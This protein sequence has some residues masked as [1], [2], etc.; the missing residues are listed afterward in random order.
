M[1]EWKEVRLGDIYDVHNGLSKGGKFFGSGFPFLTFSVVFNNYFVPEELSSLVQS[2]EKERL[3]CSIK[4]GD[5]FITR[6]S[7]TAEELGMSCVAL[8]DYPNATYNGFTKRL[9]KKD[10]CQYEVDSRYIGYY[11]RSRKFRSLFMGLSGSMSTRA[12]L[13]NGDLLNMPVSLPSLSNQR[14]IASILSSLDKKIETYNKI[15]ANLEEMAQAIFKNWF[16]DF[17]PFKDG[18]FVES[19]LGMIP[20]G[21]RVGTIG[22]ITT[23][24]N[25]SLK[26]KQKL[27]TIEY[28]DTGS[29]TDNIISEIQILNADNDKIPSRA[30][31]LVANGDIVYSSVRPNQRHFGILINPSCNMVVSTG[32]TVISAKCSEYRYFIYQTL[33]QSSIIDKFQA[34]A[35]HS[36]STYPS[37]NASDIENLNII[38]PPIK[39][40]EQY[41]S[42]CSEFYQA[43]ENRKQENQKLASIRDTLLPRLMSGE[44]EV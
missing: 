13:A 1:M 11:L 38:I 32:F 27:T 6:T 15:N 12:S 2:T 28:L 29:I 14:R 3:S 33:T 39:V 30:K 17:A 20:E 9:R 8:K 31:R 5:V 21:W 19:E 41:S 40:C 18:K 35:E 24:N 10:D 26:A 43:M 22:E 23:I 4:A 42:I 34:I 7:E 36:A 37:I 25:K 44:I 16:V